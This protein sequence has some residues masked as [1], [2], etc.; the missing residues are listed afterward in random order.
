MR[1][2]LATVL[3]HFDFE[4]RPECQNWADQKTFLVWE[5]PPLWVDVK[6]RKWASDVE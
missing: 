1:L 6:P 2:I 4:L 5:K 3:I